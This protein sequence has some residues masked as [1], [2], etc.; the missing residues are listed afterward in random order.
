MLR[1]VLLRPNSKPK[2]FFFFFPACSPDRA[3]YFF[4]FIFLGES[5]AGGVKGGGGMVGEEES[6]TRVIMNCYYGNM[7]SW[8]TRPFTQHWI[9]LAWSDR[10]VRL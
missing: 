5:G 3:V 1:F 10:E 2:G 6:Y 9:L 4:I 8:I 7:F